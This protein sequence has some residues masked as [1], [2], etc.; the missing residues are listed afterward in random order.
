[1]ELKVW[2]SLNMWV[3]TDSPYP[4]KLQVHVV[5]IPVEYSNTIGKLLERS[6]Y[7][8]FQQNGSN[9]SNT[10]IL[11][12]AL[13]WLLPAC[14]SCLSP[15]PNDTV[16]RLL[17]WFGYNVREFNNWMNPC[18]DYQSF[19]LVISATTSVLCLLHIS[20]INSWLGGYFEILPP[21]HKENS[22]TH[23]SLANN[24]FIKPAYKSPP[25][26]NPNPLVY[27]ISI[28]PGVLKWNI[29]Q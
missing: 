9:I 15:K 2:L 11:L 20:L 4:R 7:I 8:I 10:Y 21:S 23:N 14:V 16:N 29:C 3:A 13:H 17:G 19:M 6:F 27:K 25:T 1:M 12:R 26:T 18:T 24:D 5:L 28:N 22:G